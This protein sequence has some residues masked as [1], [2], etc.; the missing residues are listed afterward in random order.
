MAI[1]ESMVL[2]C[3]AQAACNTHHLRMLCKFPNDDKS[4][5]TLISSDYTFVVIQS[6]YI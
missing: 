4:L 6:Y 2:A 3:G 5:S 1:I